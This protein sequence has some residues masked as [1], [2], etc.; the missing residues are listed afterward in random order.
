M[1]TFVFT[2]CYVINYN[3][4]GNA[5]GNNYA[6]FSIMFGIIGSVI[7]TFIGSALV[8]RGRVG[9]KEVLV[10]TAAGGVVMGSAA[11]IVYNIGILIMIGSVTG[12]FCGIYMRMIHVKINKEFVKDTLGLFGPFFIS[13]VIGS[14]VVTPAVIATYYNK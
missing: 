3:T 5:L 13:A 10:S 6:R 9:Y 7:G 11:P 14:L 8:G 2:S 1:A 12:F 4:Y